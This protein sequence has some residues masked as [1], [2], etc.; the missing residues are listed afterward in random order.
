MKYSLI[1]TFWNSHPCFGGDKEFPYNL[2]KKYKVLEIGC[3]GGVDAVRFV[4]AGA[5]YTGIDLTDEAIRITQDKLKDRGKV[6]KMNAEY[7][8]FADETFDIVYSFGVIHH[9]I[10]PENII[11]EIYRVLK[12]GG[13]FSIMLYNKY[14]FRYLIE[15]MILRK[16][17]WFFHYHKFNKIRKLIPHPTKEQWVSINT[18]GIGCPVS[19]VYTKDEAL[20]LL[21]EFRDIKTFTKKNRWFRIITGRK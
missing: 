21:S 1:E 17:L 11:N 5:V 4:E 19:R 10:H 14:S 12:P 13:L 15:I 16:I 20:I 7:L 6:I 18:D 2:S 8:T 3:G 9:A